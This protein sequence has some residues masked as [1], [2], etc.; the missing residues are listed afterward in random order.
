[1]TRTFTGLCVAAAFGMVASLGAQT[2]GQTTGTSTDPSQHSRSSMSDRSSKHGDVTVTGCL[3][4]GADGNYILTNAS[5]DEGAMG[6]ASGAYHGGT[7]TST[8][9]G[10]TGTSTT[11]GT[12]SGTTAEA[13]HG[14]AME[15]TSTWQL[16]G[17]KDLEKHVGHKIQVTGGMEMGSSSEN[18]GSSTGTTGTTAGTMTGSTAGTTGSTAAT[19]TTATSGTTTGT[20]A[21]TTGTEQSMHHES[22]TSG[23]RLDVKSVKMVSTSCS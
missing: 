7:G 8:T 20:T 1:M 11:A 22:A 4:K 12:T 14:G 21:G 15:S 13:G 5:V 19:G 9:A 17:G 10:T 2:T 23:H 18:Y 16:Q 3:Q 6:S